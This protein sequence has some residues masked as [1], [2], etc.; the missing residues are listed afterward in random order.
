MST[1]L[2]NAMN[3]PPA[4][5]TQRAARALLYDMHEAGW[6]DKEHYYGE[7]GADAYEEDSQSGDEKDSQNDEEEDEY[8]DMPPLIPYSTT[9]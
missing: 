5:E 7:Q 1:Y 4:N 3:A 2:L 8:A 9:A 6:L